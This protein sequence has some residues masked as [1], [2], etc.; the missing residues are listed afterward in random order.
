MATRK[1]GLSNTPP[2]DLSPVAAKG[3]ASSPSAARRSPRSP[4]GDATSG[5]PAATP[6]GRK[7]PAKRAATAQGPSE[8]IIPDSGGA[9][10][11]G[12]FAIPVA[13]AGSSGSIVAE[14][15][16]Q[17]F[18][19]IIASIVISDTDLPILNGIDMRFR[20]YLIRA[21]Q[22]RGMPDGAIGLVLNRRTKTIRGAASYVLKVDNETDPYWDRFLQEIAKTRTDAG[23]LLNEKL[24][25][26]LDTTITKPEIKGLLGELVRRGVV[27]SKDAI[28]ANRYAWMGISSPKLSV[29]EML[30]LHLFLHRNSTV[31][32]LASRMALP[33]E[34]VQS[35]LDAMRLDEKS[36]LHFRTDE[37]N[38]LRWSIGSA[39]FGSGATGV[40]AWAPHV[41]DLLSVVTEIVD[42][43]M[44]GR[45]RPT[46]P[47]FRSR[48]STRHFDVWQARADLP[49]LREAV[50]A[51]HA[52]YDRVA[53]LAKEKHPQDAD[54]AN[55]S[56]LMIMF[57]QRFKP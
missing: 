13:Y 21:L 20:F 47:S 37:D 42:A 3:T 14:Q 9:E 48:F 56:R 54:H 49:E 35:E 2:S 19:E 17:L 31:E 25:K 22:R 34:T 6:S 24:F 11:R 28:F 15:V 1:S 50:D 32:E 27:L 41:I 40:A 5:S 44:P 45:E 18:A 10:P 46:N 4:A 23:V 12:Q 39:F 29:T 16:A 26:K 30:R 36:D 53:G 33:V 55:V 51:L 52:A 7:S 57:G 38:T 43:Q 8:K